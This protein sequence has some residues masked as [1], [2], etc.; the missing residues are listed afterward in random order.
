MTKPEA[1]PLPPVYHWLL[2]GDVACLNDT[3]GD[4]FTHEPCDVTC[5]DCRTIIEQQPDE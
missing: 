3:R 4:R 5:K 1:N 2:D